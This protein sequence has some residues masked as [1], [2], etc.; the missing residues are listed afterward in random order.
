[1]NDSTKAIWDVIDNLGNGKGLKDLQDSLETV[2]KLDR[3]IDRLLKAVEVYKRDAALKE[4]A[5]ELACEEI[6]DILN[7]EGFY[8]ICPL[9][10]IDED[11]VAD[12]CN[13]DCDSCLTQYYLKQAQDYF[14]AVENN[15]IVREEM[16]GRKRMDAEDIKQAKK[17]A[18][19]E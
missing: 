10:H 6:E 16:E 9:D 5:L 2:S 4:R 8:L 15:K 3:D 19:N 1:M 13:N 11:A 14:D 18:L 17:E 12:N 7:G